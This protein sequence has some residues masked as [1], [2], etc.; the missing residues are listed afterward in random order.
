MAVQAHPAEVLPETASVHW[1]P[2]VDD[3]VLRRRGALWTLTT[4]AHIVPF[5]ASAALLLWMQPLS[6][7]V[8]LV[9]LAHAWVIPEL[10]AQRGANVVRPHRRA[11][12]EP[13]RRSVGLLGD[14]VGHDQRELHARTGLVLEPGRLGTWLVGEAG[15]VLLH[16]RRA[17][18]FCVK[19]DPRAVAAATGDGE[20]P[21]GDRIAHLLLALRSDEAGFA[22]VANLSF[23]GARWRLRRRL[24]APLRP[25]LDRAA[26]GLDRRASASD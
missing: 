22:T 10:Y 25:A 5:T 8:A 7:P 16:R 20:L 13:E 23:A 1:R 19:V 17:Y 18:C 9:L 4:V 26:A 12:D 15:A 3:A 2:R 14:L 11:A 6:L 21:S 24:A